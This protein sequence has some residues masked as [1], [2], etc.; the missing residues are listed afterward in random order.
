MIPTLILI[1]TSM[2]MKDSAYSACTGM[3]ATGHK[4]FAST[5]DV[6]GDTAM[7][8][9]IVGAGSVVAHYGLS[10]QSVAAIVAMAMGSYLGT[11]A[12][13]SL[14]QW[15]QRRVKQPIQPP[16]HRGS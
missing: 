13:V 7:L 8:L 14:S 1:M 3:I 9:S 2:A 12:G 5:F 15:I 16:V 4:F 10:W 6:L 11:Y